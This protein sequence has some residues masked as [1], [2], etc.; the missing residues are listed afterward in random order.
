LNILPND[1][2]KPSLTSAT[3]SGPLNAPDFDTLKHTRPA[4]GLHSGHASASASPQPPTQPE[5]KATGPLVSILT[6]PAISATASPSPR[7][8]VPISPKTNIIAPKPA[9]FHPKILRRPQPTPSPIANAP[10]PPPAFVKPTAPTL[11]PP[12]KS[13][14]TIP[15]TAP[16]VDRRK[17]IPH[18]QKSALLSL[19]TK[20]TSTIATGNGRPTTPHAPHVLG[21]T[22]LSGIIS[23]VS[24]ASALQGSPAGRSRISSIG[25][26]VASSNPNG[27][28]ENV[29]G[30]SS[31][32]SPG[33][34]GAGRGAGIGSSIPPPQKKTSSD[35]KAFLL[36]FLE[37]VT[38]GK[39]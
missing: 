39:R 31:A 16:T 18:D 23:P 20:P 2:Q 1:T 36:G 11:N 29:F 17:S 25:E 37:D 10:P 8:A 28:L 9:G 15:S 24:P 32:D 26:Q 38:R 30:K 14:T 6:R 35:N 33:L 19:F 3:V 13:H 34:R 22:N 5:M 27:V 4:N 12:S 7:S 21:N